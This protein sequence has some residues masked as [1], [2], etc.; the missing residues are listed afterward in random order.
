MNS[1][2]MTN[3][4]RKIERAGYTPLRGQYREQRKSD[5]RLVEVERWYLALTGSDQR[6]WSP[7]LHGYRT[8]QAAWEALARM[9]VPLPDGRRAVRN[10][11]RSDYG[12]VV[13]VAQ[14]DPCGVPPGI[15]PDRCYVC[16][17]AFEPSGPAQYQ[18]LQNRRHHAM[19]DAHGEIE[20]ECCR[21]CL[22]SR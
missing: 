19:L 5:G 10:K 18:R 2:E 1:S 12:L 20:A 9:T 4:R 8:L 3:Y 14:N 21:N 6:T 22:T 16:G 13:T 15:H 17:E 11:R 7:G